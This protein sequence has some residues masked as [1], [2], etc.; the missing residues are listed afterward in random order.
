MKKI[1]NILF[2]AAAAVLGATSCNNWLDNSGGSYVTVTDIADTVIVTKTAEGFLIE[3][4]CILVEGLEHSVVSGEV[5]TAELNVATDS[6]V[7][8]TGRYEGV[9]YSKTPKDKTMTL[10][11][12]DEATKKY[13][14]SY[15][16][17]YNYDR[18]SYYIPKS[19]NIEVSS[20]TVLV[21]DEPKTK[22]KL[23]FYQ[24]DGSVTITITYDG[25]AGFVKE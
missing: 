11:Y 16:V 22:Y 17:D 12:Y 5:I 2:V 9:A 25:V 15:M 19:G 4:R 18:K 10:G 3:G 21:K 14:G 7:V 23:K 6:D 8:P 1:L 20:E 13:R 24:T